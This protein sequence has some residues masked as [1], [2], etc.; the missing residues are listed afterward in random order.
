MEIDIGIISRPVGGTDE[1][2]SI[3]LLKR[4]EVLEDVVVQYHIKGNIGEGWINVASSTKCWRI[5]FV[6]QLF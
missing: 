5:L 1:A 6:V 4:R 3:Q 2:S